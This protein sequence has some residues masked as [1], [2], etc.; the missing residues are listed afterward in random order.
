MPRLAWLWAA[1]VSAAVISTSAHASRRAS[2]VEQ[3][4]FRKTI[5]AYIKAKTPEVTRFTI[6]SARVSTVDASWAAVKIEAWRR[7]KPIGPA[8]V[9]LHY[10]AAQTT[11]GG[12]GHGHGNGNGHGKNRGPAQDQHPA[13]NGDGGGNAAWHVVAF[14]TVSL[15]C[16]LPQAVQADLRLAC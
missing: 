16:G 11:G 4:G 1:V 7:G 2:P 5:A 13:G 12:G 8:T 15:G 10:A 9:V 6:T 3:L 14:G